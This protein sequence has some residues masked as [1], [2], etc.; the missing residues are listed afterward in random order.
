M[1]D[2]E[3]VFE[4]MLEATEPSSAGHKVGDKVMV[5]NDIFNRQ[6]GIA[7]WEIEHC[8]KILWRRQGIKLFDSNNRELFEGD[9]L[10]SDGKLC[11]II[12]EERWASFSV[13]DT[14]ENTHSISQN[15]LTEKGWFI[16]GN[17]YENPEL[18]NKFVQQSR[19]VGEI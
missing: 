18:S 6:N 10:E 11:Q 1:K 13:M 12:W 16:V 8:W 19:H 3:I 14:E 5:V 7:F 2:R 15:W 9:I 17:I 4:I